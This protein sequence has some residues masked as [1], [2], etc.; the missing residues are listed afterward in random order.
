L[1]F[2]SR[3]LNVL[4]IALLLSIPLLILYAPP[5]NA[6]TGGVHTAVFYLHNGGNIFGNFS[7][8]FDWANTSKPYNPASPYFVSNSYQGIDINT[9]PSY[10][11]F[12]W[13]AYPPVSAQEIIQGNVTV[14]LF[15]S[16]S[17]STRPVDLSIELQ[18]VSESVH[19]S[20][21]IADAN[22][23]TIYVSPNE[24]LTIN[25]PITGTYVL[26][27]G[28][29]LALNVTRT[30]DSAVQLYV[31]FDFNSTPSSFS[32][33][34]SE[35]MDFISLSPGSESLTDNSTI[36]MTANVSDA[37]GSADIEGATLFVFSGKIDIINASMSIQ[38][39]GAYYSLFNYS[40]RL[41]YGNYTAIAYAYSQSTISG[42]HETVSYE[43]NFTVNPSLDYFSL[44]LP[45]SVSAGVSFPINATA[46]ADNGSV[47]SSFYGNATLLISV[48]GNGRNETLNR[49]MNFVSGHASASLF[50][51]TSGRLTGT[52]AY[53]SIEGSAVSYV[54]PGPVASISVSP[55]NSTVAAGQTV[56]F[57]ARG[58]D[59]FGNINDS[60]TPYWTATGG[61]INQQGSFYAQYQ[62]NWSI[63]ATDN[64]TGV[65]G[66]AS[67]TISPS[68]IFALYITP[69]L[70][71]A[72]SGATYF[73][74]AVGTD[75][76]GNSI[77]LNNVLW[78]TNA[79]SLQSNGS[80][81][82][83]NVS[84]NAFDGAW[85]EAEY[86]GLT[87]I[88]SFNI[89][90][91]AFSPSLLSPVPEQQIDAG[92]S[93]ALNLSPYLQIPQGTQIEWY[94]FGASALVN[95]E[96]Q[97]IMGNSVIEINAI[98]GSAGYGNL[99]VMVYDALGY[100]IT[101]EI[102]LHIVPV[103]VWTS[104]FPQYISL[105]A[106]IPYTLN[107][108]YFLSNIN[109]G[110]TIQSSSP[111]VYAHGTVLYYDFPSNFT[112]RKV[113]VIITATNRWNASASVAQI[114]SIG[115]ETPPIVNTAEAPPSSVTMDAGSEI[116]LPSPLS[117]YFISPHPL[118]FSIYTT[119][120]HAEIKSGYLHISAPVLAGGQNGSVLV[121][122]F[123]SN[124]YA[125]LF[126]N[127]RVI[128]IT[129]PPVIM[130][131]PQIMVHYSHNGFN[132]AF[133]LLHYISQS[134]VPVS[135]ILVVTD[136]PY[137][138]FSSGNF[139][140]MFSMPANASGGSVYD[141]P[142]VFRGNI[143]FIAGPLSE[144]SADSTTVPISV[145]V[146]D[147]FPPEINASS[148]PPD[149]IE[150]PE[151]TFYTLSLNEYFLSPQGGPLNFTVTSGLPFTLY[152]NGSLVII[153]PEY[154]YGTSDIQ[155]T[156]NS[157]GLLF[158]TLPVTVYEV[159]IPPTYF[160]P[161]RLILSSGIEIIN[162]SRYIENPNREALHIMATGS[163]V[164]AIGNML[165]VQ[166]PQGVNSET[167]TI[168]IEAGRSVA[169]FSILV[170]RP[171]QAIGF[172][173]LLSLILASLLAAAV[174]V[175]LERHRSFFRA[176]ALGVL[177]MHRDGR[178]VATSFRENA[179][180]ADPDLFVNILGA[181]DSFITS[182]FSGDRDVYLR[183]LDIA[184]LKMH[185]FHS[186]N[187]NCILL[188]RGNA[189][190]RWL[191]K[192]QQGVEGIERLYPGIQFWDGKKTTLP[193]IQERVA[194]LLEE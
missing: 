162:L 52:V 192:M 2:R 170:Q 47:M 111:Y 30:D 161:S 5:A 53:G 137:I 69:A 3:R 50:L 48:Q 186:S 26:S 154:Y 179:F 148:P 82:V 187:L 6:S 171:L 29:L 155:I 89:T 100:S 168:S 166:L 79:G 146:S 94:A 93:D 188:Y 149:Y 128:G 71:N 129:L 58:Y 41:K 110:I 32:V 7:R 157:S 27:A 55:N 145:L 118:N 107:Y 34:M 121:A 40:F 95:A 115:T 10:N 114:V 108:T 90:P 46:Y 72:I 132:Y 117:S 178:L 97:G 43:I 38:H 147:A 4:F 116:V 175:F 15:I 75:A 54:S 8:R 104:S 86:A 51:N 194:M 181:I 45:P 139:S 183:E 184:R 56:N 112:G 12:I 16:A 182:S 20:Q 49:T 156:V 84:K 1:R 135:D 124:S 172:Y 63:T 22:T 164:T 11:S 25:I 119:V 174:I 191:A 80:Y 81:A 36:V 9:T 180:R 125:F 24:N 138:M 42:A 67:I 167:I 13:Y 141:G 153:P 131:L 120:V 70:T 106:S 151:N 109:T 130:P 92:G 140:L 160:I 66:S 101:F 28:N 74:H 143:T 14:T 64:S 37:L 91:S 98:P 18:N 23:G 65:S 68:S 99:T 44:S 159:N 173:E 96:G 136:T 102:E 85:I 35:R 103:P 193:G 185:I 150:F 83:L 76:F 123:Y 62:G 17:N 33:P 152:S 134:A 78:S 113:A 163:G 19:S 59:R 133:P 122:A 177:L 31:E 189:G 144:L 127:V 21:T 61:I 88:L 158:Y 165:I 39:S 87:S 142:Y 60:W 190:R 77:E 57:I 176:E 105:P 169:Y 126:V 73:F